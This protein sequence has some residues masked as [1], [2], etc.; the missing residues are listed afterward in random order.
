MSMS[1]S[2]HV[3]PTPM[4][5]RSHDFRKDWFS[6]VTWAKCKSVAGVGIAVVQSESGAGGSGWRMGNGRSMCAVAHPPITIDWDVYHSFLQP[7][8]PFAIDVPNTGTC[9]PASLSSSIRSC[10]DSLATSPPLTSCFSSERQCHRSNAT[11]TSVKSSAR[12]A[13]VNTQSSWEGE[14]GIHYDYLYLRYNLARISVFNSPGSVPWIS[15]IPPGVGESS[16]SFHRCASVSRTG[17]VVDLRV[18]SVMG[19]VAD[20]RGSMMGG[21]GV[22]G[23][24]G[25]GSGYAMPSGVGSAS[26][27]LGMMVRWLKDDGKEGRDRK[28]RRASRHTRR[29]E[30]SRDSCLSIGLIDETPM[31]PVLANTAAFASFAGLS[32]SDSTKTTGNAPPLLD[33]SSKPDPLL[34]TLFASPGSTTTSPCM[35]EMDVLS[36]LNTLD[37]SWSPGMVMGGGVIGRVG[38]SE[39][40]EEERGIGDGPSLAGIASRMRLR[41]EEA[42]VSSPLLPDGSSTPG[43]EGLE[44]GDRSRDMIPGLG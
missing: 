11:A 23:S 44:E 32:T 26:P 33:L 6:I 29:P 1:S 27:G 41:L 24:G 3:K 35:S 15:N 10:N 36:P 9:N 39:G 20:S 12:N 19:S 25:A 37:A 38:E 40:V 22:R 14:A 28:S 43:R 21:T 4:K 34:S 13:T 31:S 8:L 7:C 5:R 30:E 2:M 42:R 18:G 17:S 16:P